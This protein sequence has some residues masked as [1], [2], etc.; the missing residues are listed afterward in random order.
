VKS[1]STVQSEIRLALSAYGIVIRQNSGNFLTP[2]GRRVKC[3]IAGMTDLLFV[4]HG[5]V[6]FIEVKTANGNTTKAQENFITAMQKLGHRAGV[7]RSVEDAM[8]II[9]E[10]NE[11]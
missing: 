10:V 3:G 8:K 11:T 7:A 4:G 9:T 2:D 1:E 6:A 5:Y